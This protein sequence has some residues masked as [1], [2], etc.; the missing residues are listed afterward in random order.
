MS[1]KPYRFETEAEYDKYMAEQADLKN[2]TDY[3]TGVT[4]VMD[5]GNTGPVTVK[6]INSGGILVRDFS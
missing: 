6:E 4:R 2:Y 5:E 1:K 3:F